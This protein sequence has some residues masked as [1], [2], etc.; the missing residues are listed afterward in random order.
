MKYN[1]FINTYTFSRTLSI[2][3]EKAKRLVWG[4]DIHRYTF[5]HIPEREKQL[6][7]IYNKELNTYTTELEDTELDTFD[8]EEDSEPSDNLEHID[9]DIDTD[10]EMTHR[11]EPR[12]SLRDLP[13]FGKEKNGN[14]QSFLFSLK[15]F[16]NYIHC[17]P[18]TYNTKVEQAITH[19]GNCLHDK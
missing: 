15:G 18:E 3:E 6:K 14:P 12:W 7:L 11:E 2:E 16:L 17:N 4:L 9:S 19:L 13:S 8:Q 1:Q 10:I 5:K